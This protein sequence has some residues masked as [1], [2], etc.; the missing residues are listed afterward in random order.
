MQITEITI[1]EI[2]AIDFLKIIYNNIIQFLIILSENGIY[3]R[4]KLMVN[5]Y[6]Q[7]EAPTRKLCPGE[8][9]YPYSKDC[10]NAYYKCKR[11]SHGVLQGYLFK[12]SNG[13]IFSSV[14]RRCERTEH[15]ICKQNLANREITT[16]N[17]HQLKN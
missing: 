1:R 11:D 7:L 14:S 13:H 15:P 16:D 3:E 2:I 5:F 12:C 4:E 17:L 9:H 6:F 10:S 8:G